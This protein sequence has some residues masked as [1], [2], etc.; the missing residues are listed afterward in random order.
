[1]FARISIAFALAVLLSRSEA[2]AQEFRP[3]P[4]PPVTSAILG[5]QLI[6]WTQ[7]QDPQPVQQPKPNASP[8]PERQPEQPPQQAP[9]AQSQ[10]AEHSL[11]GIIVKEGGVYVLVSDTVIY[12]L[13][14]QGRAREHAHRRVKIT[15]SLSAGGDMIHVVNIELIS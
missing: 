2:P 4:A 1:M 10:P 8:L 13:D 14:D 5:P 3:V 7:S 12:Q 9:E 15:G 6:A 11:S